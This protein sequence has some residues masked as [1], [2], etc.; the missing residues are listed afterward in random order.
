MQ[1][2]KK[3]LEVIFVSIYALSVISGLLIA[4]FHGSLSLGESIFPIIYVGI[5][6]GM[7]TLGCIMLLKQPSSEKKSIPLIMAIFLL[8]IRMAEYVRSLII[9]VESQPTIIYKALTES[10]IKPGGITT[11]LLLTVIVLMICFQSGSVT[12]KD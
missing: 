7:I 4:V 9:L 3:V 6:H 11:E 1:R 5:Y 12:S 10:L 8:F 2:K